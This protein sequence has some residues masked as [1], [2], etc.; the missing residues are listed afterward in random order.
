M[1]S[2]VV[3]GGGVVVERCENRAR[4]NDD[5]PIDLN[6]VSCSARSSASWPLWQPLQRRPHR[7]RRDRP[8]LADLAV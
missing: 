1:R 4:S 2:P 6:R 7:V 5:G 8:R 3:V